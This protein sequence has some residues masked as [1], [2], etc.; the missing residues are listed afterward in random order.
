[1]NQSPTSENRQNPKAA[2]LTIKVVFSLVFVWGLYLLLRILVDRVSTINPTVCAAIVAGLA[3]TFGYLYTQYQTKLREIAEAHRT[4]KV[5]VYGHLLELVEIMAKLP[6]SDP[7]AERYDFPV[8][9]TELLA[10]F[11]SG[12]IA[13]GSP[14]VIYLWLRCRTVRSGQT[15]EAL[16]T[17]D[18]LLFEIR[19]DLGNSDYGLFRG[20]LVSLFL[21]DPEAINSYR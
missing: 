9:K 6:Q 4:H 18:D 19:R 2:R 21:K 11:N 1:M 8:D 12:V 16:M 14:Y 20:D 3:A 15:R 7:V 13:W 5:E 17:L 10:K